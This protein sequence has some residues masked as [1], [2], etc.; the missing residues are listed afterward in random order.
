MHHDWP[1]KLKTAGL[2][3][4][5][6]RLAVLS[7]LEER[8]HLG[9]A[10]IG[11]AV[12]ERLGSVSTQALYDV[13]AAL[14]SARLIRRVEPA[15]SPPRYELEGADNHHHAVCRSCGAMHDVACV[16]GHAPCL[17]PARSDGFV[18]DEA[19]VIY[20]GLCAQCN[21]LNERKA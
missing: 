10:D 12:R 7:A 2:R 19:E 15:G 20:W 13:P 18:V 14:H 16:T 5:A 1:A 17:T 9:L 3:V 21:E 11:V 4:T 6:G 8:P